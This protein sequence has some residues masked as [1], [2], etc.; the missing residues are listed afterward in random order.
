MRDSRSTEDPAAPAPQDQAAA[1][2]PPPLPP[3]ASVEGAHAAPVL[4]PRAP[5]PPPRAP[6]PP[7]RAPVPPPRAPQPPPAAPAPDAGA[8]LPLPPP[9]GADATIAPPPPPPVP[10]A[11]GPLQPAAAPLSSSRRARIALLIGDRRKLVGGLAVCSLASGFTESATLV[12]VAELATTLVGSPHAKTSHTSLF[13]IHASTGT[14]LILA[15]VLTGLRLLL[16]IPLSILPSR[17]AADV[18]ANVRSG[19]FGS[20]TRAS[21][22]VQSADREGQLQET[23]TGQALQAA[24][25]ANQTTQLITASLQFLML[26]AFA[27]WVNAV[28]ALVVGVTSVALFG[29]LRPMRSRGVRISRDLSGAQVRYAGG[30]AEAN[31]LAEETQVFG[32]VEAQRTR[33]G[34]LIADSQLYFYRAQLVTRLITNIY[35]SLIYVLLVAGLAGLYFIGGHHAGA[36]G[37][38]VLLLLRAG[39]QGQLLQGA[40]QGLA[41]SMPFIE[42]TQELQH[43]YADSAPSHGHEPLPSVESIA[44]EHVSFGYNDERQVLDDVTFETFEG[45]A[46]GIVGPSGAGKSTLVQILLGL[47]RPVEGRYLVNAS[48]AEDYVRADWHH[49]V[50]YVPQEPRLLHASVTE[51]IRFFR[52][53]SDADV[54]RAAR[55]A[56]IHD[57]VVA[58]SS[59]YDTIVGPRADAVSGGQQQRICLARALA[60]RPTVLILDEPTSALDP[61]SETL[62]SQSLHELKEDLTLFIVAH[63]M[64]TLEM[65]DRVMVVMG[66]KLVGFDTRERLQRDNPYYRNAAELAVG[67]SGA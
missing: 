61:Q 28:A 56:R 12:L 47:R 62:I 59:G 26:I 18:L 45:E 5:V 11:S 50:S 15:F 10:G 1:P 53:I 64:S 52:D 17:I 67:S 2:L 65:C 30:V 23:L 7:P 58:W 66:G 19:L 20:F 34:G 57:D 60:A 14:L 31:R 27:V 22:S 6:V 48:P 40:Y 54:E 13:A 25:G 8:A 33:V 32:V 38:I 3:P 42:R 35:Q 41:Q 9:A 63:R 16:Q 29:L 44:F 49:Q 51:N 4:P 37:A 39:T 24:S 46:I 43:R 55:L 36:L 21:W